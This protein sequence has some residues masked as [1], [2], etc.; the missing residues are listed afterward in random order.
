MSVRDINGV[1]VG[2]GLADRFD[3]HFIADDKDPVLRSVGSVKG[4]ERL[5]RPDLCNQFRK[6]LVSAVTQKDR[7]GLRIADIHV[8]DPVLFLFLSR[9]LVLFDDA[10]FV[11]INGT[12]GNDPALRSFP[13]G[14]FIQIITGHV[15]L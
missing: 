11:I 14:L 10:V 3:P 2:K 13:E 1:H 6:R 4:H 9:I 12:D 5:L 15:I 7:T 8:T